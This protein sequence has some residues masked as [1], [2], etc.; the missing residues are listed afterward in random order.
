MVQ[1]AI[2]VPLP[3]RV[4]WGRVAMTPI[5]VLGAAAAGLAA[6]RASD[7]AHVLSGLL[8]VAFYALLVWAY[9][10]RRIAT[11]TTRAWIAWL[12]APAGTFLPFTLPFLGNGQ[13]PASV[14]MT[15]DALLVVGLAWAA[16]SI[17]TLDRSLS[18]V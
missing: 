1:T 9:L 5:G 14:L 3:Y 10:R 11:A 15:G 13:P 6:L 17:R 7:I 18:V 16:W 8:T 12:V 4:D 2:P